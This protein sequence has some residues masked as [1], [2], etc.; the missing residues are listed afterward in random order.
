MAEATQ[1]DHERAV[2]SLEALV[3]IPGALR[4]ITA[5]VQPDLREDSDD[6]RSPAKEGVDLR[7]HATFVV[8]DVVTLEGPLD[9]GYYRAVTAEG[10]YC[11]GRPFDLLVRLT[12][13]SR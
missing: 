9:K 10:D 6:P 3:S 8:H 7:D 11:L 5:T 4:V 12:E 13:T 1:A 2:A